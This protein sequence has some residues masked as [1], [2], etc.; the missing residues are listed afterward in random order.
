MQLFGLVT[1]PLSL[2]GGG[3][4]EGGVVI[5]KSYYKVLSLC[6]DTMDL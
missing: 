5:R 3:G 2:G 6:Y 1:Q 4:G